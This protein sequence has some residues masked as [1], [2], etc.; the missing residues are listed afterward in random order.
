MNHKETMDRYKLLFVCSRNKWR[1]PTAEMLVRRHPR[2]E[3]RSAGTA[4][5]ARTRVNAGHLDW[6]DCVVCMEVAHAKHLRDRF[7][8]GLKGKRLEVLGIEDVYLAMD[9]ELIEEIRD[10]LFR[11]FPE[12]EF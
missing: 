9:P 2:F 7:R 8:A 4:A 6:A 3:A 1:S 12:Y 10:G 11:I 5:S